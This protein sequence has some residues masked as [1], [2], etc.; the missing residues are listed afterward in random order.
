MRSSSELHAGVSAG[1]LALHGMHVSVLIA[2]MCTYHCCCHL[3]CMHTMT[4]ADA[5]SAAAAGCPTHQATKGYSVLSF[6]APR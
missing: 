2:S 4:V 1:M 5:S 6:E 3:S